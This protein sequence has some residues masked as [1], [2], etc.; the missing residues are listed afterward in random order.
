MSDL[1]QSLTNIIK[2]NKAKF[3]SQNYVLDVEYAD[4][5]QFRIDLSKLKEKK[6]N[7]SSR[8]QNFR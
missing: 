6:Y 7:V 2:K 4:G 8:T 1:A 3:D 5:E